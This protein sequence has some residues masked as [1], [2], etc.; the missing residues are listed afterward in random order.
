MIRKVIGVSIGALAV[1]AAIPWGVGR[2]AEHRFVA[3][4]ENAA[5]GA[6]A[7]MRVHL[8]RYERGWL[9][10]SAVHRVELTDDA[11][12]AFEIH[13]R[14]DHLPRLGEG[15]A[16]V[17]S[18][19][20]WTGEMGDAVAYYFG[21]DAPLSADTVVGFDGTLA[22]T[23]HSP[24]FSNV[25][26]EEPGVKVTWGGAQGSLHI[27]AAGKADMRL[28]VPG[29]A[30]HGQGVVA[31]FADMRLEGRWLGT[32]DP[33]GW[34][35]KTVLKVSAI[36][37]SSPEGGARLRHVETAID[38]RDQGETI[39]LAYRLRIG[40][41]NTLGSE[42][43]NSFREGVIEL[44]LDGLDKKAL[45]AYAHRVGQTPRP[46]PEAQ[47]ARVNARLALALLG[48]LLQGAPELRIRRL[49]LITPQGSFTASGVLGIEPEQPGASGA[50]LLS[51]L[52]L[53]GRIDVSVALLEGWLARDTYRGV[54]AALMQRGGEVDKALARELTQR[55]VRERIESWASAGI[56]AA[57]RD[58]YK[59]QVK[60]SAGH[61]SVN[62]VPSDELLPSQSPNELLD[63]LAETATP[64]P[65]ATR[66]RVSGEIPPV[67]NR[68]PRGEHADGDEPA[69]S[70]SP[71]QPALGGA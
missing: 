14:I 29:L 56:L 34:S 42:D 2:L 13:H 15:L 28:N 19:P 26:A 43:V 70:R 8:V 63:S 50:D 11:A 36:G 64:G 60:L 31:T 46:L 37:I 40:E 67:H 71:L 38:R 3:A 68:R 17:H 53:E 55:F 47:Q 6:N 1:A 10:S 59:V 22:M 7:V 57:D 25:L 20:E 27:D 58:R 66:P 44:E 52:R 21:A 54:E 24:A 48:D 12:G 30:M 9:S 41:G 33:G 69:G 62:G 45:A 35:G 4:L 5:G 61:L 39:R 51:R 32:A 23:L 16:R 49:G 18:S 65:G